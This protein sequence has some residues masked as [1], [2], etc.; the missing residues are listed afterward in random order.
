MSGEK[1]Y[2]SIVDAANSVVFVRAEELGLAGIEM[3]WEVERRPDAKRIMDLAERIRGTVATL[4]P[5]LHKV[6]FYIVPTTYADATGRVVQP[7][8]LIWSE[9]W[10]YIQK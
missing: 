9:G 4:C 1:Y 2:I 3:P 6:G 5:A 7:N 10:V 8:R